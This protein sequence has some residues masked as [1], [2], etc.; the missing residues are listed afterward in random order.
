MTIVTLLSC[1]DQQK[2]NT[3][4]DSEQCSEKKKKRSRCWMSLFVK[5]V[6]VPLTVLYAA[7]QHFSLPGNETK[8]DFQTATN[9]VIGQFHDHIKLHYP[10]WNEDKVTRVSSQQLHQQLPAWPASCPVA[11][12]WFAFVMRMRKYWTSSF[13]ILQH[14]LRRL[15]QLH[16]GDQETETARKCSPILLAHCWITCLLL[17]THLELS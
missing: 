15:H 16:W 3:P 1:R 14:S 2:G 17:L 12:T 6:I 11:R 5:R 8:S 9:R 7:P 13:L 10:T 4:D